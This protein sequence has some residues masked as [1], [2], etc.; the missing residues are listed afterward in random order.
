MV[1]ISD[2]VTVTVS[3]LNVVD[4]TRAGAGLVHFL[5]VVSVLGVFLVL[6][7]VL[8]DQSMM[9]LAEGMRLSA[10]DGVSRFSLN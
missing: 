8:S 3:G 10:Q 9:E 4:L 7:C 6:G 5:T 2:W 1:L